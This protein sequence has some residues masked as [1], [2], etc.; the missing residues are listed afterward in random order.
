M[1]IPFFNT[2]PGTVTVTVTV[3]SLRRLG[4]DNDNDDADVAM[5]LTLSGLLLRTTVARHNH[6]TS[7]AHAVADATSCRTRPVVHNNVSDDIVLDGLVMPPHVVLPACM[8]RRLPPGH[9]PHRHQ[10]H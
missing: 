5:T 1:I 7:P 4:N 2:L 9:E 6:C 8:R 10:R 3:T